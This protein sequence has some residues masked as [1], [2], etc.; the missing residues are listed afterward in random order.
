[1]LSNL[2]PSKLGWSNK[3]IVETFLQKK[4]NY[5]QKGQFGISS[6]W[7]LISLLSYPL[8]SLLTHL[9]LRVTQPL[10]YYIRQQ[11]FCLRFRNGFRLFCFKFSFLKMGYFRLFFLPI[12]YPFQYKAPRYQGRRHQ[13]KKKYLYNLII[14]L[15]L[16]DLPVSKEC[17]EANMINIKKTLEKEVN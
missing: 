1:M 11:L 7:M 13:F 10:F 8:K 17:K 14:F 6:L 12:L 2:L 4:F 15:Q 16:F 9:T 3:R 5:I